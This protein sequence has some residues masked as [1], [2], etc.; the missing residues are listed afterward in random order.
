MVGEGLREDVT[1]P[2]EGR[3]AREET[4]SERWE[5][6]SRLDIPFSCAH[7]DEAELLGEEGDGHERLAF[8]GSEAVGDADGVEDPPDALSCAG[9]EEWNA[10]AES[11]YSGVARRAA[12]GS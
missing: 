3:G 8:G 7:G 4:G 11:A 10:L 6:G 9:G 2:R 12:R 1:V 5:S